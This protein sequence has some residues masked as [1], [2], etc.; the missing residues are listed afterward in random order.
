MKGIQITN[1][2][3]P[4]ILAAAL[5]LAFHLLPTLVNAQQGNRSQRIAELEKRF[6]AKIAKEDI[7]VLLKGVN[8]MLVKRLA[9]NPAL[10]KQ[11]LENL[12]QLTAIALQALREND[13]VDD[14]MLIE[15]DDIRAESIARTYDQTINTGKGPFSLIS[16]DRVDAFYAEPANQAR[17]SQ[18]LKSKTDQAKKEGRLPADKPVSEDLI[19]QAKDVYAKIRIYEKEAEEKGPALGDEYQRKA[20]ISVR[21]QQSQYLSGIYSKTVIAE[22]TKVF[23]A[24]IDAY[25]NE[26]PELIGEKKTRAN[27]ILQMA[28]SG[29]DFAALANRF[30]DDPGNKDAEGR[31]QGGIYTDITRGK[32]VVPFEQ[33]ALALEPG[34]ISGLVETDYGY[35]ILKLERRGMGKNSDGKPVETYD[36]RHILISTTVPNPDNPAG[37]PVPVREMIRTKFETEREKRVMDEILRNNPVDIAEDFEVPVIT[38]EQLQDALK[39]QTPPQDSANVP[40]P[41][42]ATEILPAGIRK[43]LNTHYRGWKLAPSE[44]ACGPQVNPG[45]IRGD[46]DGDGKRDY[47]VKFTK[48]K[49][50]YML[51]FL[52]R[53]TN[54]KAF[55]LHGAGADEM[56]YS[57]LMLWKR[58]E[59]FEDGNIKF[60]LRRDAPAEYRCESDVG[61][62]HYYRNGKFVN[63]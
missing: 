38:D 33:A 47:A 11:Q 32:M 51:A 54:Y 61:G 15:L 35:H 57:G 53:G 2:R 10:R 42:A 6:S 8:P 44:Y 28:R 16:E 19:R 41:V 7:E 5:F 34:Q 50:G 43:Y 60:R 17:F 14:G 63:Y 9:E 18:F 30:T 36:V 13:F 24:D 56:I 3:F 20:D 48:G 40:S 59:L 58:G 4:A 46:F 52:R 31:P 21:L 23:E 49:K 27:E 37:R 1:T 26:H 39:S 12:H 25:L 62:I 29:K 45:F 22:K 55:V